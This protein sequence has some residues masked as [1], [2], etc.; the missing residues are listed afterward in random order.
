MCT[1]IHITAPTIALSQ[2]LSKQGLPVYLY[3]F[4]HSVNTP[5]FPAFMAKSS[6][7]QIELPF[8]FGAPYFGSGDPIFP[9]KMTYTSYDKTISM[10]MM[11]FWTNFTKF[12]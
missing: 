5:D 3:V 9:T 11:Q 10:Y 6:F 8:V 12:G 7:H 1:D 2:A 4:D